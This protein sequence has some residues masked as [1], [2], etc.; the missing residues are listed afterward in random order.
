MKRK[1]V[2]NIHCH[3]LNF[4]FVPDRMVKLLSRIPER[5]ADDKWGA[6]TAGFIT[7][8]VPG[9][10][11]DRIKKYLKTYRSHI[12]K[13]AAESDRASCSARMQA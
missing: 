4:K 8:I 13:V 10:K 1:P 5:F 3:L 11:F 6:A 12:D 7:A 9:P 2:V